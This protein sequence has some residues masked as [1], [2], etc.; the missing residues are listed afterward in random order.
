MFN[1]VNY[2]PPPDGLTD[3]DEFEFIELKNITGTPVNLFDPAY[4]TNRW[5][6]RGGVDFDFPANLTMALTSFGKQLPP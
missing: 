5:R 6:L 4:P 3:G 2:N 1:E